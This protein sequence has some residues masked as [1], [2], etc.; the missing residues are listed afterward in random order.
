MKDFAEKYKSYMC[1]SRTVRKDRHETEFLKSSEAAKI[2]IVAV[3][4]Q[5]LR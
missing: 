4:L 5:D 1:I 3:S 2:L